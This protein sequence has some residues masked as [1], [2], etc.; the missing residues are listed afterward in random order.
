MMPLAAHCRHEL[1]E[2]K[3]DLLSKMIR[4]YVLA[5]YVAGAV[6]LAPGR[7]VSRSLVR[8]TTP[9]AQLG[10]RSRC[11]PRV[12]SA[13]VDDAT[14]TPPAPAP[15]TSTVAAS[16]ANLVKSIVGAGVLSLPSGIAAFADV[17]AALAPAMGLLVGLGAFSAYSFYSL[18]RLCADNDATS[19]G[20][21]YAKAVGERT[22]FLVP[23]ACTVTPILAC[24]S[25][26]I[27]I[28]DAFSALARAFGAKALL[29]GCVADDD[30]VREAR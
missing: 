19:Y 21:A 10:L 30:G 14:A 9:R 8:P 20:E 16:S 2:L 26:S 1:D 28:G 15:A 5:V 6:A 25:Y 22:A 11:A 7:I 13:A 3:I 27:I 4:R 24:L 29:A 23:L 18:G 12:A 17:G